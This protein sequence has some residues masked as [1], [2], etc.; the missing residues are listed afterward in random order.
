[1][2]WFDKISNK[3]LPFCKVLPRHLQ[4]TGTKYQLPFSKVRHFSGRHFQ[5]FTVPEFVFA[6]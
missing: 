3:N 1:M 4:K 2:Y 6:I 5:G